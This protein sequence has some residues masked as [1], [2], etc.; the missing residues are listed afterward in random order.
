MNL[1]SSIKRSRRIILHLR[2]VGDRKTYTE[3]V[4][5]HQVRVREV[6]KGLSPAETMTVTYR[7]GEEQS[8]KTARIEKWY[9][10]RTA[11]SLT[12]EMHVR[13]SPVQ[14]I[15]SHRG[16]YKPVAPQSEPTDESELFRG[17]TIRDW[18]ISRMP[19]D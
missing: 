7:N 4:H 10:H 11:E 6:G 2:Y 17:A 9:R 14:K 1:R 13:L 12:V 16:E 18:F 5:S 15:P 3:V 8:W 19:E